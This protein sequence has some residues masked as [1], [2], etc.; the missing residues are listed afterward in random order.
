MLPKY[1]ENLL[2]EILYIFFHC[3]PLCKITRLMAIIDS[4]EFLKVSTCSEFYCKI[5]EKKIK[6]EKK[7]KIKGFHPYSAAGS[8]AASSST[9]AAFG[10]GAVTESW[11]LVVFRTS[12]AV[13]F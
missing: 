2:P 4:I 1:R 12:T 7:K 13:P 9:I 6:K 11:L 8:S 3:S 10:T 5:N